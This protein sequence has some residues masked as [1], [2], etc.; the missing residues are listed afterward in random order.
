MADVTEAWSFLTIWYQEISKMRLYLETHGYKDPMVD[1]TVVSVSG[2]KAKVKLRNGTEI[3]ASTG[4][5]RVQ[6]TALVLLMKNFKLSGYIHGVPNYVVS[7][8]QVIGVRYFTESGTI[9]KT[10]RV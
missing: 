2:S 4:S 6:P 10:Y 9:S 3:S 1:G 8:Y 7:N 5:F